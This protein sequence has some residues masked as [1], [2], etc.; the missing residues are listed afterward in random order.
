MKHLNAVTMMVIAMAGSAYA[1]DLIVLDDFEQPLGPKWS[2]SNGAEFP[3]ASG[4]F[5]RVAEAT[6]EGTGGGRLRFDFTKGGAYVQATIQL[7]DDPPLAA[8]ELWIRKPVPNRMT[9]RFVDEQGQ[10]FQKSFNFRRTGWQRVRVRLDSWNFSWGGPADGTFHGQPKAF[11]IL[12]E[13]GEAPTGEVDIDTLVGIPR[14]EEAILTEPTVEYAVTHF[15]PSEGWGFWTDGPGGA[16]SREDNTVRY[17]FSAGAQGLNLGQDLSILGKPQELKLKVRSD[18]SGRE[19]KLTLYSHFQHFERTLGKLT[20][21]GEMTFSAPLGDLKEWAHYGGENDG[22]ARLPL[23]VGRLSIL[24][25]EGGPDRGEIALQDLAVRTAVPQ[26]ARLFPVARLSK[27]EAGQPAFEL[28]VQS[29]QPEETSAT[30]DT[31]LRDFAGRIPAESEDPLTL[32]AGGEPALLAKPVPAGNPPFVEAQFTVTARG[33]QPKT[34]TTAYVAPWP[35]VGSAELRPESPWGMGLYLYRYPGNPEGLATMDRAAA[36]AQAAGIKWSREEFSWGRIEP[37]RGE[38]DWSFY[39]QVVGT[40]LRHGV[41]VYGLID[42]WSPWTSAYT[43]EGTDD[44]CRYA[45]AL[46]GHYKDR[47]HHWEIWNEPNIFFWSGPKE[48]YFRLLGRAYEAIKAVD[49]GA[50]V[51]GC[52]TAGIDTPFIQRTME[53]GARF[54]G[55]TVHPYRGTLVDDRFVKELRDTADLVAQGDKRRPVWITEMGWSTQT[56]GTSEREQANLLARCYLD[57]V[58]SGAVQNVS[59]YDF[60]EDGGN[61]DYN[62][63]HF[64]IVRPDLALKPAYRAAATVCR[65]LADARPVGFEEWADGVVACR[66]AS[67]AGETLA[68]WSTAGGCILQFAGAP[69]DLRALNLMGEETPIGRQADAARLYLPPGS[70]VLISSSQPGLRGTA[71]PLR[72]VVAEAGLHPGERTRAQLEVGSL[73]ADDLAA[74]WQAPVGWQVREERFGVYELEVPKDVAPGSYE[75]TLVLKGQGWQIVLPTAVDVEPEVIEV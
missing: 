11:G 27:D 54:D 12:V 36:L 34:A 43:D 37:R 41:S 67:G 59:W 49:P 20:E 70:P 72:L 40:A 7:P 6:C 71:S 16:T 56:G 25:G 14:A 17:D 47:V 68:V 32:P 31:R 66:F 29:L 63:H 4:S 57:S 22:I 1:Q 15:L 8:V 2:F 52:S 23:R 26:D 10:T 55:L 60:R 28:S 5:E 50:V 51:F 69:A 61:P 58:A 18:G 48:L 3:G 64:G 65:T 39:D 38:F 62:E 45:Q 42:Y 9:A 35:D 13:K 75:I 33:Q 30:V 44:Y 19:V 73:P 74:S 46:V 53:A 24:R 21:R